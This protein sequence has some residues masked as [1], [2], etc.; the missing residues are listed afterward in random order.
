M[1]RGSDGT[2][3][4]ARARLRAWWMHRQA[5]TPASEPPTVDDCV[6]RIGWVPTSGGPNVYLSVRARL[7]GVSRDAIDRAAI[8]G[9]PLIEVPGRHA[10]PPVLVPREDMAFALRL[11]RL[12]YE[13][14]VAAYVRRGGIDSDGIRRVSA[15]ICRTL[16][17]GPLPSA[18]LRKRVRPGDANVWIGALID[19]CLRGVIRRFPAGARL[20]SPKYLYELLHPDDRPN[21]EAE[22]DAA[23]VEQ[24]AVERFLRWHGPATLA[25]LCAWSELTRQRGRE[26]LAAVGAE[27]VSVPGWS[28]EGW[29]IAGDARA[30]RAFDGNADTPAVMLPYRD[31]FVAARQGPASLT[32]HPDAT[33]LKGD[34]RTRIGD[35]G[36]LHHHAIVYRG[37]LVGLWEYDPKRRAVVTRIWNKDRRIASRIAEAADDTGEFIR[38]QLG[39]ARLSAVDPPAARAR[40]LAFC[41][42]ASS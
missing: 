13:R 6:R 11:H 22:G 2:A 8:D 30:W 14:H 29:L 42:G 4:G 5:L 23:L 10:R 34:K 19:L 16:D 27:T 28:D 3:A 26:A 25:E 21:L 24:K 1:K 31:P 15:A 33:V 32:E 18:D 37:E 36:V 7:R 38:E 9:T 40:R 35:V 20:D 17:E 39:D 41:R 12:S